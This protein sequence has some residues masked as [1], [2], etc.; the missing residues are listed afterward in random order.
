MSI[1]FSKFTVDNNGTSQSFFVGGVPK[2]Y[3]DLLI[4]NL[5]YGFN[6]AHNVDSVHVE[7]YLYGEEEPVDATPEEVVYMQ[8]RLNR[9]PNFLE[10]RCEKCS[11]SVLY[12]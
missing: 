5:F 9:N 2:S 4:N 3:D 10:D 6:N 7:T 11:E 1:R 8:M 12:P